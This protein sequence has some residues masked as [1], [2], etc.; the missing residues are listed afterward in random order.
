M[1]LLTQ[2]T[3]N[4]GFG[5]KAPKEACEGDKNCP[6]HG[7]RNVRGRTLVGKVI[8][9]KLPKCVTI[10]CTTNKYIP[11]YQRYKKLRTRIKAHSPECISASEGE[12]VKVMETRKI[13]KTKNFV[14]VEKVEA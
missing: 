14:V 3:K 4:I 8:R 11:K 13:S 10:E 1:I 9:A 2:E 7:E 12:R 5:I 6:F